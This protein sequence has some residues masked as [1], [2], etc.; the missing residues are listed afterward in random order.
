[1]T[2]NH[3]ETLKEWGKMFICLQIMG[4]VK[5]SLSWKLILAYWVLMTGCQHIAKE[6]THI[7]WMTRTVDAIQNVELNSK[8]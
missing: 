4:Q 8:A 1:M 6:V 7:M 3:T 5:S 2:N